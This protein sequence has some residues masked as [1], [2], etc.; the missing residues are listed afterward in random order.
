MRKSWSSAWK[1]SRQ[2]R[3]QRKY[4]HNAPMH[5]KQ[6]FVRVH[7]NKELKKEIGCR[8]IGARKGD[9]VKIMRG[10]FKGRTGKIAKVNLKAS[11]IQ[12]DGIKKQKSTGGETMI[13]LQPS[14]LLMVLLN[15]DDKKR[16]AMLKKYKPK[17]Q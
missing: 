8:T 13:W 1:S 16:L 3:K 10:D 7:L 11:R 6:K 4:R 12:V 17:K 14:N 2:R 9:E 5:I 15:K